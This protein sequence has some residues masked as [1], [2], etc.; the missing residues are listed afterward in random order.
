M[1][2]G[3]MMFNQIPTLQA[4]ES[5]GLMNRGMVTS[6]P[7]IMGGKDV[8]EN[9]QLL[10]RTESNIFD[11]QTVKNSDGET[12][13]STRETLPGHE[14]IQD[15]DGNQIGNSRDNI[16]GGQD[17]TNSK[18]EIVMSTRE[19]LPGHETIYDGD[20]NWVGTSH[21]NVFGGENVAFDNNFQF[22]DGNDNLLSAGT[23]AG[24]TEAPN[25]GNNTG[26]DSNLTGGFNFSGEGVK[27]DIDGDGIFDGIDLDGDGIIDVALDGGSL[28]LAA[29]S[30]DMDFGGLDALDGLDGLDNLDG[31]DIFDI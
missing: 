6:M 9:G 15:A 3:K 22:Q 31:L 14:S 20:G 18:G 12:I 1:S 26:F 16:F 29:D 4:G 5:F 23:M 10:F 19:S 21:E 24:S 30:L 28:D 27:I 2:F 13:L 11:G 8:W 17:I 25:F 7:N